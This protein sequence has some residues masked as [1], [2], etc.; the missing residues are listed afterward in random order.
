VENAKG[1]NGLLAWFV[2]GAQEDRHVPV[3]VDAVCC[4]QLDRGWGKAAQFLAIEGEIR[5]LVEVKL[6][7][8]QA[9][10]ASHAL[11]SEPV[12]EIE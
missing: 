9:P 12:L 4:H 6:S 11:P 5:Q 8:V 3:I 2:S 1:N 7:V 10:A